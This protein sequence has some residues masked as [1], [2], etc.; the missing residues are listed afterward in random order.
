MID[1]QLNKHSAEDYKEIMKLR[2]IGVLDDIIQIAYNNTQKAREEAEQN[3]KEGET[4]EQ[5]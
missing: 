3:L 5:A 4:H 2:K 1:M